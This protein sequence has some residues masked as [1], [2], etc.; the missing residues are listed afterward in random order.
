MLKNKKINHRLIVKIILLIFVICSVIGLVK[1]INIPSSIKETFALA[2]TIKPETFTELYFEDHLNLPKMIERHTEYSFVFTVH[3]VESKDVDYPYVV[4]LQRDN[5]KIIL[6]QGNLN[7]KD[8]EYKSVK[9]DFGPLKILGL[10]I[11][12]ELVN[13]NQNISFWMEGGNPPTAQ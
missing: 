6:D 5:Q 7:L 3:N 4:Y 2:T 11:V 1:F 8:N 10:K 12:V 9:E 13:E